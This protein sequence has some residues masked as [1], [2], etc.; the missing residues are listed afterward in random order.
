VLASGTSSKEAEEDK[1]EALV[2]PNIF[3]DLTKVC[4]KAG[5]CVDEGTFER[6][7]GTLGQPCLIL[8]V[9]LAQEVVP[10]SLY[11]QQLLPG[12]TYLCFVEICLH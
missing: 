10:R 5:P 9:H 6:S 7:K 2:L 1:V 3:Q 11:I 8:T 4:G 12:I